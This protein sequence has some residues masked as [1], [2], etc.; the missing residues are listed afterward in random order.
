M[1][2]WRKNTRT[3]RGEVMV[4]VKRKAQEQQERGR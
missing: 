4:E 1:N 3:E 2:N